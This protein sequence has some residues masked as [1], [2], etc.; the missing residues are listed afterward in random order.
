[1]A[2]YTI[3]L[4][5]YEPRSIERTRRPLLDAGYRVVLA[6]DGISAIEA[7]H[8]LRPGLVLVEAMIPKKHGFEVC[9]ELKKTPLGKKTPILITTSVYKGRKYRNQAL[10][11]YGCDDYL[12]K[13]LPD[14][15]LVAIC[16]K[17]LGDPNPGRAPLKATPE[18][19]EDA[20]A[21]ELEIMARL[22]AILPG[23]APSGDAVSRQPVDPST[24]SDAPPE[25]E[26][27]DAVIEVVDSDEGVTA[28][29]STASELGA[30]QVEVNQIISFEARKARKRG[31]RGRDKQ[32]EGATTE[33]PTGTARSLGGRAAPEPAALHVEHEFPAPAPQAAPRP[34]PHRVETLPAVLPAPFPEPA[35][36][37]GTA[38]WVWIVVAVLG[39]G[40]VVLYFLLSNGLAP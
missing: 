30:Q 33:R 12:E 8:R 17:F 31:H 3:L 37:Q 16:A 14:D 15:Q 24:W 26:G 25:E 4:I 22:D 13:P 18:P 6:T 11:L 28:K 10:H 23:S 36:R 32:M 40:L 27:D 35:V 9:Q 7:F 38:A 20:G 5:D 39:L 29:A 21:A 19:T 2:E 34:V 1:M